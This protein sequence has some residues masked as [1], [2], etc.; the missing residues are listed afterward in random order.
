MSFTRR[1]RIR[2]VVLTLLAMLAALLATR[3]ASVFDLVTGGTS[4]WAQVCPVA[5]PSHDDGS[6]SGDH[7]HC[8]LCLLRLTELAPPPAIV[9]WVGIPDRPFA[10]SRA[11][12][13]G[14]QASA[15]WRDAQPRAPPARA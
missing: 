4:P 14:A 6:G 12:E 13:H 11:G 3:G 1:Q 10:V 9:P 7:Q 15:V 2:I 8:P 5:D